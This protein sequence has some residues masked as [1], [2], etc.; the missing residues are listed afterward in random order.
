MVVV[1][2][3]WKRFVLPPSTRISEP[4]KGP[5]MAID[6]A[7]I[8]LVSPEHH[9][10]GGQSCSDRLVP[11]EVSINPLAMPLAEVVRKLMTPTDT[12]AA[13]RYLYNALG[14][15]ALKLEYAALY[16]GRA[17]ISLVGSLELK[18]SCDGVH[19]LGQ[20]RQSALQFTDVHSVSVEV[21]GVE[22]EQLLG[23]GGTRR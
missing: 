1:N 8:Y 15:S 11:L 17:I 21:N 22:L 9:N 7:Y 20:L 23:E 14:T 4:R 12:I 2:A 13:A 19:L 18:S 10:R 6:R 16:R 5:G 3:A